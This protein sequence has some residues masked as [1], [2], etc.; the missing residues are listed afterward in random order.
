MRL[1][2]LVIGGR[3]SSNGYAS[4]HES[5]DLEDLYWLAADAVDRGDCSA[6]HWWVYSAKLNPNFD[7]R[8]DSPRII[9]G[10]HTFSYW[11]K[12]VR[13]EYLELERRALIKRRSLR[14]SIENWFHG[15]IT[16]RQREELA[17][18]LDENMISRSELRAASLLD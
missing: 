15:K 1:Y 16:K 5:D 10:L 18:M 13:L 7:G 4:H 2:K 9:K 11:P 6:V 8:R 17:M 3:C 12:S 14:V